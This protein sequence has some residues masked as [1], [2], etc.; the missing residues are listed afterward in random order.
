MRRPWRLLLAGLP[1]AA[2]TLALCA[3]TAMAGTYSVTADTTRDIAGWTFNPADGIFGCS[4]LG[5]TGG[6]CNAADV[7]RPSPLRIFL[8]GP[9]AA[10]AYG[11]WRWETP[12]GVTILAGSMHLSYRTT[13]NSRV[14]LRAALHNEDISKQPVLRSA[15]D[16]GSATWPVPAGKER[17]TV[18][19]RSIDGKSYGDKW[20]NSVAID[21]LSLTLRDDDAPTAELSGPLAAGRWE[22]GSQPVCLTVSA[23]DA[24]S[25]VASARLLDDR[26]TEVASD[27]VPAGTALHPGAV[28][29]AGD[30]CVNPSAYADGEH[31]M[32]VVVRDVAGESAYV[33]F[34]LRVDR[35][36]PAALA[37]IPADRTQDR[38]TPVSFSVDAGPSGLASLTASVDDLPMAVS[39]ASATFAPTADLSYG[40]HTVTWRAV[41]NAGNSR[42]GFWTF[43]VVDAAAPVLSDAAPAAGSAS[44]LR[45]PQIAFTLTDV[46][47]GIDPLTLRVLLDGIDVAPA[48]GFDGT[49]FTYVPASDLA[50]GSHELRVLAADR[51]GN[52][53][54]PTAWTFRVADVTAPTLGDPRP[55]AG[56]SSSDR[57]PTI[58]LAAFDAGTGVDPATVSVTLDGRDISRLGTFSGGRFTY[59]PQELLGLGDHV[60]VARV[61]DRA[62]NPAAPFE[63]HFGVRD[64]TAPTIDG[65]LPAPGATVPGAAVIGFDVADAGS[66]IDATTLRVAVDASDV[67]GWGTFDGSRFR[68]APGNL[69]A[70]V[71]TIAVTVADRSGNLAGPVMWQFAVASPAS[72]HLDVASGPTQLVFGRSGTIVLDATAG[73]QPLAGTRVLVSSRPAGNP[74]FG[75]A[76]VLITG[77]DGHVRWTVSP[78]RSATFRAELADQPSAAVQRTIGVH[79]R[80]TI[81]ADHVAVRRGLPVRLSGSVGPSAPAARVTVQL[82]TS[83]GWTPVAS[84]RLGSRSGY[85]A[86][87]I[88]RLPGRYLLRVVAPATAVNLGGTSRTVV[89]VVR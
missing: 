52:P 32:T 55:D 51:S 64:E 56:S 50:F 24:G 61:S 78:G 7:P 26:G 86:T 38:R 75:P 73:G 39:G 45:R 8:S 2:A 72:V 66:G 37:M 80:V 20:Q 71:H 3:G 81:A 79:R 57:T 23:A 47:T 25:G 13:P 27:T 15:D 4:R 85:S 77:A 82:L 60:V 33:P 68:Y 16:D 12:P 1:A 59:Q 9:V 34:S 29:Y 63:W 28:A 89:V 43:R 18:Q 88:P 69:G 53:L 41:D 87:V 35:S 5:A 21:S 10:D 31:A 44:E 67:T 84:P 65:R 54:A 76:R 70:G 74:A 36:A 49:R 48:G 11:A 19:L 14:Q 46:G 58:S 40:Q 17:F 30:L 22:S 6:P 83:R 42:D 62:G